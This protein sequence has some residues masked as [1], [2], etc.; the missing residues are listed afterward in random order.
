MS[1]LAERLLTMQVL[2]D[3]G[4]TRIVP[5][6]EIDM[7]SA[8]TFETVAEQAVLARPE[9]IELD[10]RGV[11]FID[12]SGLRSI[13]VLRNS[14]RREG[15]PLCAVGLS[16]AAERILELTGLIDELRRS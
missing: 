9:R 10:L 2:H 3:G 5:I 14:A 16:P 11:E 1:E 8:H 4:V 15:I 7:V 13:V 12:S 6:G